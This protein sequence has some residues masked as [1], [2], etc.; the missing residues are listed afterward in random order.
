MNYSK[1]YDALI[2]KAKTEIRKKLKRTDPNFIYYENHHIIP[3][4]LGGTNDRENM[5]LLTAREHLVAHW[6]LTKIY[7]HERRI[8]FAFG[9]LFP[10]NSEKMS[11]VCS[12][13]EGAKAREANAKALYESRVGSH[14][15]EE[16]KRK[17]GL[18]HKGKFISE[19]VRKAMSRRMKG[20]KHLKGYVHTEETR[21]K[22]RLKSLE[23][24]RER[25]AKK[26]ETFKKQ[27][28][29]MIRC[30]YCKEE[31]S[32]YDFKHKHKNLCKKNPNSKW[33]HKICIVCGKE[34]DTVKSSVLWCSRKCREYL[35]NQNFSF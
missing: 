2:C 22:L 25:E 13:L 7:P 34:F 29:L 18:K 23:N 33:M 16:S 8:W 6:I 28:E 17:I 30:P 10:R 35:Q 3:K 5:V 32:E 1:I 26:Q 24:S 27:K 4:C 21:E 20:N 9:K 12:L 14:F 19:E 31:M 11:R 15:S